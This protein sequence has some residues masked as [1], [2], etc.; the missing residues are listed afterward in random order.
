[1]STPNGNDT[2]DWPASTATSKTTERAPFSTLVRVDLGGLS[3]P[4]LVRGKNEDHFLVT[5]F[6]RFFEWL[7]SNLPG[8]EIPTR[9]G[10]TGYAMVVADGIGGSAGGEVASQLAIRILVNLALNTPDWILLLEEDLMS[11]EVM[12]RAAERWGHVNQAMAE[13]ADADP[14]LQGFGTT[15][16]LA[17]SL[18]ADLFVAHMG[19]SRAYLLRGSSLHQL[20]HD[21]TAA[22]ALADQGAIARSEVASHRWR[23]VLTKALGGRGRQIEPDVQRITLADADCLLLCTDGLTEMVAGDRIA[24][25]LEQASTAALACQSLV[26]AALSAGG[27]D[28]VTVVVARYQMPVK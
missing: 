2:A 1:M 13:Q 27:K 20:T 21:H 15:L 25:I 7:D 16:T 10:E 17:W 18:G 11:E 19:D 14:R 3:H 9:S 12:R 5:R 22:Q 24:E 6:G 26:D 28:N 4:G 8:V 23:H